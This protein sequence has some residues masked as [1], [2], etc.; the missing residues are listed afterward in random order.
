MHLGGRYTK[1]A[2]VMNV[3]LNNRNNLKNSNQLTKKKNKVEYTTELV[4]N[5]VT[6]DT[7]IKSTPS[8]F[9]LNPY[10]R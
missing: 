10:L 3:K 1:H 2:Y 9:T 4:S 7:K 5:H 8:Q 6:K